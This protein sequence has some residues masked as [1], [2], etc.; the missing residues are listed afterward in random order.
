M[1]WAYLL[2]VNA[3]KPTLL[4]R[5]RALLWAHIGPAARERS[6][7]PG[8]VE[9]S[10]ISM[11]SRQPCP[12]QRGAKWFPHA[13]RAIKLDDGGCCARRPAPGARWKT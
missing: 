9:T 13:A 11:V 3:N 6:V 2:T 7:V 1:G 8:R 4:R 10:T 12:D 5:L